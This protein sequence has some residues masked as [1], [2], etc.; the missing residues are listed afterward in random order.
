MFMVGLSLPRTSKAPYS[1]AIKLFEQVSAHAAEAYMGGHPTSGLSSW[2]FGWP[3]DGGPTDFAEAVDE[4]CRRL[5]EGTRHRSSAAE[6]R[7]KDGRLDVVAWRQFP[8][9][10]RSKLI[11]VGQCTT[12]IHDSQFQ[13]F[14]A[15]SPGHS[16][17][18]RY[19]EDPPQ[20]CPVPAG[21]WTRMYDESG[22]DE[23]ECDGILLFDRVRIAT[24]AATLPR[25]LA[26]DVRTQTGYL[27]DEVPRP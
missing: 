10:R 7:D 6:P 22:T 9:R 8:D 26:D 2:A 18:R 21:F 5:G 20:A 13:K 19:V 1:K 11:L 16:W 27:L 17:F 4:L 3:R 23:L 25:S 14:S 15:L 12:S 24:L